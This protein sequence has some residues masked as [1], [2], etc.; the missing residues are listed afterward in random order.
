MKR[1]S[2]IFHSVCGNNYILA[3]AFKEALD[4]EGFDTRMYNVK[5]E[6]LHIWSNNLEAAN[7]YYEE[8]KELPTANYETLLKSDLIILGSP[9]YFG[10]VSAEMKRFM[11]ESSVYFH[12]GSLSGK[13]FGCFTSCSQVEGG[14]E[15]CLQ[16]MVHYAQR[17]GMI[18]IP[19][20]MQ[21]QHIDPYQPA[22]GL[23][24][25]SGSES[26]IRPSS[27][28]GEAINFYARLLE[29]FVLRKAD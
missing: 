1:C 16:S 22:C 25:H 17:M 8:I 7:D 15:L 5:D 21:A 11:D 3:D 14:G 10:N 23:M 9:T 29:R 6:D 2:I 13:F 4:A 27:Q 24:H 20:G 28:L 18:H 12:D 19:L 26:S